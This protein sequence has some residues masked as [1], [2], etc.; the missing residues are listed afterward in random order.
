MFRILNMDT[1]EQ[2][3][4]ELM[5]EYGLITMQDLASFAGVSKGLVGQWFSGQ[6][7][8]GKKPLLNL[9][10][11]TKFSAEWLANGQGAKYQNFP[12]TNAVMLQSNGQ[13]VSNIKNGSVEIPLIQ[14]VNLSDVLK[15]KLTHNLV[16]Y[17]L[18]FDEFTLKNADVNISDAKCIVII[19]NSMEPIF[20]EDSVI[21]IDVSKTQP[22][23][24]KVYALNHGGT[25]RV[26]VVYNLPN[27][28]LR[29]RSYNQSEWP[30]EI[31]SVEDMEY[32][33]IIGQLFWSSTLW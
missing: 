28:G 21:G 15:Q 29:L 4:R 27:G 22:R 33:Q 7:G 17:K 19:G 18:L 8:L 20:P 13:E 10:R 24:G 12:R 25:L 32:V 23:D 11:K 3:L 26:K 9:V 6:T 30:D 14:E 16:G 1:L 31:I 2:R 5:K